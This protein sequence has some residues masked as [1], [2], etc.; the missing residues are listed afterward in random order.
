MGLRILQLAPRFI[1]PMDDG[2]KIGIANI[3]KQFK[4][5]GNDVTFF[6]FSDEDIPEKYIIEAEK[7][8]KLIIYPHSTKNSSFRIIKGI[9][10][11]ES[12]YITKHSNAKIIRILD[13]ISDEDEFDIVHADHTC[14][15]PLAYHIKKRKRIPMGLRLHNIEWLIWHRYAQNLKKWHPKSFFIQNQAYLLRNIEKN[16]IAKSDVCFPITNKDKDFAL[17]LSPNAN[18]ITASGGVNADEWKPE[19]SIERNPYEIVLATIYSWVHNI[20]GLRWFLDNVLP[21]V[22]KRF[23]QTKLTLLGKNPPTWLNT[24][25][26]LGVDLLGHVPEVQPY[27]NKANLFIV[28][29]FVGSGLRIKILEAMAMELTVITTDL[30]AEGNVCNEND[31]IFRENSADDF[32]NR[33]IKLFENF[34]ATREIGKNARKSVLRNY[35]WERNVR[36]MLD[37]YNKLS[38]KSLS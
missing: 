31:G 14:M 19:Q 30:G 4:E 33:I 8:A 32:I 16:M 13:R 25:Q 11:N 29:L 23:P 28:P 22:K 3:M 24:Y 27:Y 36:I 20:D 26:N 6:C 9:I 2:G 38:A 12:I 5:Q 7:Y 21:A 34:E 1:F 35:S 15:G 18:V 10:N 37:N 17:D